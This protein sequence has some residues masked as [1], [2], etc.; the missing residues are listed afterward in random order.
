[1]QAAPADLNPVIVIRHAAIP[2]IM[3]QE[4]WTEYGV[5][6]SEKVTHPMTEKKTARNPVLMTAEADGLPPMLARLTLDK[7]QAN[8]AI[9]LACNMAFGNMLGMVVKKD[10]S[11]MQA[12]REKA[13][14]MMLP[15]VILQPNGI[16]G[17]TMAQQHGC[18][19]VNAV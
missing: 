11:T 17:I 16:F 13:M 3:S 6:K 2:L 18:V 1:M 15:G 5:G 9:V 4:F 8:G 19:F 12:A 14:R 10:K 7:L